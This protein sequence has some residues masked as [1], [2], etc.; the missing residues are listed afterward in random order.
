LLNITVFLTLTVYYTFNCI[1][2]DYGKMIILEQPVPMAA[3]SKACTVF[4]HSNI[5]ITDPNPAR[6]MDVSAFFLCCVVLCR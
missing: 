4:G 3:Q 5:G 2:C 6:G 1:L